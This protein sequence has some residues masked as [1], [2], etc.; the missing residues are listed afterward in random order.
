MRR[1]AILDSK[2]V[3]NIGRLIP[4]FFIILGV[5]FIFSINKLYCSIKELSL[6]LNLKSYI[7][8]KSGGKK[9]G[10]GGGKKC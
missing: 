7:M 8:K 2:I 4:P 6:Q 5:I 1:I 3:Y 9:G 10:K